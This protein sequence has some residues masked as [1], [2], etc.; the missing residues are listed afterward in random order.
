MEFA[1]PRIIS[2]AAEIASNVCR[3]LYRYEYQDYAP[4]S[5]SS[6]ALLRTVRVE[7]LSTAIWRLRK[8]ARTRVTVS[9]EVPMIWA[10]SSWVSASLTLG[11]ACSGL[12][13]RPL[14]QQPR[15][16]LR[17]RMGQ[18]QAA[19][20]LIGGLAIFAEMLRGLQT[21]VAML[22]QKVEE[23]IALDEIQLAGLAQFRP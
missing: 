6:T 5:F 11:S 1:A 2:Q 20:L 7:P 10:I 3:S 15:Q 4:T 14:Q 17:R 18:S 8:S 22:L 16:A 21:G 13:G 12:A 9:R 19:N 23:V